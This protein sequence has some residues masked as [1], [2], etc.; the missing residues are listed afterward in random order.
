MCPQRSLFFII[1]L[2]HHIEDHVFYA[3]S[4]WKLMQVL[5]FPRNHSS[6]YKWFE[7]FS[8]QLCSPLWQRLSNQLWTKRRSCRAKSCQLHRKWMDNTTRRILLQYDSRWAQF[9][10]VQ[11]NSIKQWLKV[12]FMKEICG[13]WYIAVDVIM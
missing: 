1:S 11:N 7:T 10:I 6:A 8:I 13:S 12:N 2:N 4:L 9:K 3:N 5:R